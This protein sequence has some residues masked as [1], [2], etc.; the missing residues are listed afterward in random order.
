MKTYFKVDL[1]IQ[2]IIHITLALYISNK[3]I[4]MGNGYHQS[5]LSDQWF[6]PSVS[7]WASTCDPPPVHYY[8]T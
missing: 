6:K 7:S 4:N 2:G 5:N 8:Q 1:A 3:N